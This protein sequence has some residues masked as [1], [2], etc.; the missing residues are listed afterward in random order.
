MRTLPLL[1]LAA[2]A[3]T[4]A[5]PTPAPDPDAESVKAEIRQ[6]YL[7]LSARDWTKFE[8]HFADGAVVIFKGH[9]GAARILSMTEFNAHAQK[10]VDG[11]PIYEEK[12]DTLD[13]RVHHDMAH[14]WSHFSAKL[15]TAE[16]LHQWSGI[17]AYSLLRIDGKW[18][19]AAIAISEDPKR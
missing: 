9:D 19:I 1:L 18:K 2:C 14:A 6:M 4:P 12:C 15:G 17:D 10:S 16:K 3:A 7:D 5:P 11:K 8:A 13:A